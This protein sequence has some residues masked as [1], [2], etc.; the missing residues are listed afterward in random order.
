MQC[1]AYGQGIDGHFPSVILKLFPVHK[2]VCM[3]PVRYILLTNEVP[4]CLDC[5]MTEASLV[6][7]EG[8]KGSMTGIACRCMSELAHPPSTPSACPVLIHGGNL[9]VYFDLVAW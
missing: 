4:Q 8:V 2:N 1:L 6:G 7:F 3:M 5:A 9:S